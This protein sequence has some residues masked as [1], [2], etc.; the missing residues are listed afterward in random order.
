MPVYKQTFII[1]VPHHH[2]T[3]LKPNSGE[4]EWNKSSIEEGLKKSFKK[5]R[6]PTQP[7]I[8]LALCNK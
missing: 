2:S 4:A 1:M 6:E 3:R 8:Q 5:M 7:G